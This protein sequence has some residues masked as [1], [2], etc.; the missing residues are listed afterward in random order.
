[1]CARMRPFFCDYGHEA[2]LPKT[3]RLILKGL[4][5]VMV[6]MVA[7]KR[8][9]RAVSRKFNWGLSFFRDSLLRFCF[10]PYCLIGGGCF[11]EM[12]LKK[13]QVIT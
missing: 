5:N 6:Q 10:L 8:K 3:L 2:Y 4:R 11:L 13:K 7:N 12:T 9:M 1:M